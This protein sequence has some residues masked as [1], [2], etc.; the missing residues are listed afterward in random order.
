MSSIVNL[1]HE[2]LPMETQP[3]KEIPV[4]DNWLYEPKWDGF[5]CIAFCDGDDIDLRSKKGQP[6]SR[7]FPE[8]VEE[9]KKLNAGDFVLDGELMIWQGKT[10]SFDDLLQRIHPAATRIR[11]LAE[12][13]PATYVV[14]DMLAE[15]GA[16]RSKVLI[17]ENLL[18]RRQRLEDFAKQHIKRNSRIVLSP[19]TADI[20]VARDW[21]SSEGVELDGVIGKRTDLPY[22]SGNRKGAVKI[23]RIKT[24]DCVIGGFRYGTNSKQVGSLLLGMY[25]DEGELHHVGFTSA[26]SSSEKASLTK[27]LEK[28]ATD[29]SFTQSIPGGPSRWNQGKESPWTPIDPSLVVEVQFDHFTNG[30]FRHG[31]KIL[32]WRPDKKPTQCT[33][34]QLGLEPAS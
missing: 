17:E 30:R 20:D 9:L 4:G 22:Q 23:K 32:R 28:L 1:P 16:R 24:A 14:F 31:T 15:P 27:K 3:V 6:L 25:D 18:T 21:L 8:V 33:F 12:E 2:Y 13:T 11:K 19:A 5:R 34:E 29:E 7:Y 26:L 10:P